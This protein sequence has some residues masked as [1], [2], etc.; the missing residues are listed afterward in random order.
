MH[1]LIYFIIIVQHV[2][3]Y[4]IVRAVTHTKKKLGFS[5]SRDSET[6]QPMK[7]AQLIMSVNLAHMQ[8]LVGG[9][10]GVSSGRRGE[11]DTCAFLFVVPQLALQLTLKCVAQRPMHQN[12]CFGGG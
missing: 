5:D 12:T 11:D 9:P 6:T 10:K 7:I 2:S 8:N 1:I 3:A 4:T